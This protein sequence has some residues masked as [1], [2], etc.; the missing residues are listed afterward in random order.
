[1]HICYSYNC[2]Y[3]PH[4]TFLFY[5]ID[6]QLSTDLPSQFCIFTVKSPS[7]TQRSVS[8]ENAFKNEQRYISYNKCDQSIQRLIFIKTSWI[9]V[10]MLSQKCGKHQSNVHLLQPQIYWNWT[11]LTKE[12][13]KHDLDSDEKLWF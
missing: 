5:S 8:Q 13:I 6:F 3:L 7:V 9:L 1:M 2:D 11:W 4:T 12:Y 10:H